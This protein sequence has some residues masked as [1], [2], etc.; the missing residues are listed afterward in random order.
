MKIFLIEPPPASEKGNL[1]TLGSMGTLKTDMAWPPL[2]LMIISGLLEKNGYHTFILDANTLRCS[3]S[4]V[5][6]QIRAKKPDLVVFTTSTPT[7]YHDLK[8]ADITKAVSPA[9]KTAAVGT[10]MMALPVDTL[11][12]NTNLHCCVAVSWTDSTL[13][14]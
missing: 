8:I 13:D 10:H 6:E 7:I 4:Q 1:R 2:D 9:I 12:E 14:R 5:K 11:M 3:F